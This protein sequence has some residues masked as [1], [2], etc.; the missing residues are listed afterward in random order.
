MADVWDSLLPGCSAVHVMQVLANEADDDGMN[1]FPGTRLIAERSRVS[2]RQV[3]RIV[4]QLEA[5][6]YLQIGV[7][8]QGAGVFS[9]YHLNVRRLHEEAEITRERRREER[10]KKKFGKRCHGVTFLPGRNLAKKG[11]TGTGKGD[12]RAKKGDIC[13]APLFVLPVKD[14]SETKTH[15]AALSAPQRAENRPLGTPLPRESVCAL[16]TSAALDRAADQVCSGRDITNARR[17]QVVRRAIAARAD[18][19]D[20]P[21]AVAL[22]MLAALKRKDELG[23]QLRPCGLDRFLGDGMWRDE[24]RWP[25]DRDAQEAMRLRTLASTGSA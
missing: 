2:E 12:T 17:W 10:L 20:E 5:D 6:G 3:I 7:R 16:E 15:T 11:D 21:P 4:Q 24:K 13:D 1:C 22:A 14:P 25:W 9:E 23:E 19:G 8:G 18:K